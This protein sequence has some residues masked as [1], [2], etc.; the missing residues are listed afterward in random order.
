MDDVIRQAV[1]I[2]GGVWQRRWLGLAVAWLVGIAGLVVVPLIPDRFD[3]MARIYVN[4][5]SILKPLMSELTIRPEL[6][7]PLV[8]QQLAMVSRTLLSRPN[9]EELIRRARLDVN[10]KSKA[11]VIDDVTRH[12]AIKG[13][14]RD[15]PNLYTLSFRDSDPARAK[16]VV[17]TLATIFAESNRN[18]SIR[19]SAEAKAFIDEQIRSYEKKLEEAENRL[20]EFK[21]RHL[22]QSE[23]KQSYFAQMDA[24]STRLK[25]ARLALQE[26]VKSR[27]T[28]KR[29]IAGEGQKLVVSDID[30][31]IDSLKRNLDGL[32]QRFTDNHPDVVGTRRIIAELE[33]QRGKKLAVWDKPLS[34][35][36]G[37]SASGNR[38]Y[39]EIKIALANAEANVA[40]LSARV[41]EYNRAYEELVTS[42]RQIPQVEAELAQL[43]RDYE[44]NKKNYE[45][46]VARRESVQIAGKMDAEGIG[47]FRVIDPPRVS[48][49]PVSPNRFLLLPLVFVGALG[50]GVAASFGASRVWPTFLDGASLREVTGLPF[51][52]AVSLRGTDAGRKA[53]RRGQISFFSALGALVAA[54]GSAAV[55][56]LFLSRS[57]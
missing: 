11:A 39:Q 56:M 36:T 26:A 25:E 35:G 50:A 28:L 29:E 10:I 40:S 16:R 3:A 34:E 55:W 1:A 46:L 31:R 51:I 30:A 48:S 6:E 43:N 9:V 13:E 44:I 38:A 5:Q 37:T 49:R 12:L 45:L 2:L 22:G 19:G 32:L 54:Y 20:K 57:V 41:A 17:E 7:Q 14:G 15:N 24:A 52:G 18:A 4:T 21:L 33:S 47:N 27:D 8:E 23:G 53:L 42:G